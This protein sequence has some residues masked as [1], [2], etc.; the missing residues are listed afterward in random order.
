MDNAVTV[1]GE[2]RRRQSFR[3]A[4]A[5]L[6]GGLVVGVGAAVTLAAWNDS[7]FATGTFTAGAFNL[8]GSTNGTAYAEHAAA[9]SAATLGF[10]VNP[11]NLAPA[12]IV[13]APFSVRLDAATTR[14]ATVTLSHET[15]TGTNANLTYTVVKTASPTCD[16][17]A[18]TGGTVLVPAGTALGTVP[19]GVTLS[20]TAGSGVAGT[21]AHLCFAVTAG[22]IAQGQTGSVTWKFAAGSV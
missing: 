4:R 11:T 17:T 2:G 13:Y 19:A 5:I 16:A 3:R 9:G 1:S 21:P 18:V 7:E 15:A 12:D 8:E 20:L 14:D 22:N 6:A 10:T